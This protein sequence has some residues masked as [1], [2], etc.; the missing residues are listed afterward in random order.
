MENRNKSELLYYD[1]IKPKD[2]R[3]ENLRVTNFLCNIE[4]KIIEPLGGGCALTIIFIAGILS[5][6]LIIV[7]AITYLPY[8]IPIPALA[9]IFSFVSCCGLYTNSPNEAVI[10]M[11]CG[12]YKGTVKKHGY[13]FANP[14]Y[15]KTFVSVKSKTLNS[16]IVTV[17][18]KGGNPINIGTVIV[19]RVNEWNKALFNVE[20]VDSFIVDQTESSI[21]KVC[22]Q[23]NYDKRGE[24]DISLR[25]GD[26]SI[27]LALKQELS[28]R[29]KKAGV[30]IE[31]ARITELSY[32]TQISNTMLK[33]QAAESVIAAREKIVKG[34]VDTIQQT[35]IEMERKNICKMKEHDKARLVG[36]L[37]ITLCSDSTAIPI[38]NTGFK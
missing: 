21:R 37:M 22:C 28:R 3:M 31:E 32:S 1:T 26:E 20:N 35:M 38:V 16:P 6:V 17:S 2:N 10:F 13:F 4:E 25:S 30:I 33:V 11:L 23:Y 12:E 27:Q 29:V 7:F 5:I 8:L 24:D 34:A 14:F 36:N 18:D 9:L 19:W 15:S